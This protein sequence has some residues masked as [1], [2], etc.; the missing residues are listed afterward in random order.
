VNCNNFRNQ[1][2]TAKMGATPDPATGGR[3]ILGIGAG[4]FELE[5]RSLGFEFKSMA[6][7]L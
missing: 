3:F 5:H 2:L 6:E 1:S 4:W 7:R